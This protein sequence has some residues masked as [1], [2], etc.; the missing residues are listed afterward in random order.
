MCV[1]MICLVRLLYAWA[2]H[3]LE[4][5]VL[6]LYSR[7]ICFVTAYMHTYI[8][9]CVSRKVHLTGRQQGTTCLRRTLLAKILY[10]LFFFVSPFGERVVPKRDTLHAGAPYYVMM[11][12]KKEEK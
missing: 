2:R 1:R 8:H 12:E 10:L 11:R 5:S 4:R 3:D 6:L 7:P 9:T